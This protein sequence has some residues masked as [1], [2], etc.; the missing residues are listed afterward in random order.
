MPGTRRDAGPGRVVRGAVSVTS[1][2]GP[3]SGTV[4][5]ADDVPVW[6]GSALPP[7]TAAGRLLAAHHPALAEYSRQNRAG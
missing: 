1:A 5:P 6:P 4:L 2:K 7:G 3:F